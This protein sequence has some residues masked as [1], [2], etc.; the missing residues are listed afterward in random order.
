MM[1]TPLLTAQTVAELLAR[2]LPQ[3]QGVYAVE[4]VEP[5]FSRV[6]C[7]ASGKNLRPGGTIWGPTMMGLA[8]VALY[9]AVLAS[10]GPTL[11]VTTD[12]AFHFLRK[13]EPA[14]LIGE[15][16]LFKLGKSLAV[17]EVAIRA[18]GA[19]DLVAH[20]TGTYSLPR[21]S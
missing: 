9:A 15:C 14:D 10:R 12:L 21:R 5:L 20:A 11:A 8:D 19:N 6:R 16:R 1:T 2:E 13:P 3:I 17:G 18:D 4:A 7:F